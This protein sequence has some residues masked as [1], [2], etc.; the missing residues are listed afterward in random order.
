MAYSLD[1][2]LVVGVSTRALFDLSEA[3]DV[4]RQQGVDAY[5]RYQIE[6]QRVPLAPGTGFPLVRGL[7]GIN[8]RLGETLVEVV[9]I[10]RNSADTG[11]RTRHSIK[12]LGLPI[13]RAAF[14]R[15]RPVADYLEAFSCDLFLSAEDE[16]VHS[17]L[18]AG[19]AAGKILPV[20]PSSADEDEV[21]VAF[22]GDAVLFSAASEDLYQREG[23]DAFQAHEAARAEEA[24]EGGP[25]LP[26]LR[27][28]CRIQERFPADACPVRTALITARDAVS[29]ERVVHTL[30]ALGVRIDE[31]FFLGGVRKAPIVKAFRPHIFFDD[32]I[33]HA[34]PASEIAPAAQVPRTPR[35]GDGQDPA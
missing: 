1:D 10:S 17:A 3:H 33:V 11:L 23:L 24:M 19:F 30:H 16:D 12:A 18:R 4:F 13:T 21:R 22:D 7:L 32:Q 27:A 20:P 5:T 8:A 14:T 26:F 25:F 15:G 31:C 35:E 28:L 9:I 6:N 2:K 29:H 34:G